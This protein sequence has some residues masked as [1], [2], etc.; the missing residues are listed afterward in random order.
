LEASNGGILQVSGVIV[1]NAGAN[2]T[3]NAGSAVQFFGNT[4]IQ[5]GTITNHGSFLGTIQNNVAFLDGS[6]QGPIT[7]NGT[8]TSDINTDTYL[9][10]TINNN[11]TI[12]LNG[13]FGAN[14]FL[15]PETS[16]VVLQGGG[17]VTLVSGG[18][19]GL[20]YIE[21]PT[22]GVTLTNVN[23]LIQGAGVIGNGGLTL[24]NHATVNANA[25]GQTLALDA[26][27]GVANTSLIEAS[28][29]GTLQVVGITVNNAGGNIT[30]NAGSAV[31][32]VGNAI[33]Q[34]GTLTN[35][36]TFLGTTQNNVA[37]L[38][39]NTQGPITINGTY[40][41]DINTNTYLFGMFNNHGNI[42]VNGG[43]G[44]NTF[45][46]PTLLTCFCRVGAP[47]LW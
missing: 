25:P 39:G 20:G 18:G 35:N 14:A 29:G 23:N 33:I 11:G 41:T 40:T 26:S 43:G 15:F 27:G 45:L 42:L 3:A 2:I 28:K 32:F 17:T 21:Q 31:Q 1:N 47:S 9:L 4:I 6:S 44:A 22:G 8:Y 10:G 19:G 46:F 7:I 34:G 36:G 38:D 13:G 5:G 37:F 24:I 30:A 12:L 16:S